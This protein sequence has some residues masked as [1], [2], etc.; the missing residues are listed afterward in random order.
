MTEVLLSEGNHIKGA[1]KALPRTYE[2][3]KTVLLQTSVYKHS[4]PIC[5]SL[6]TVNTHTFYTG[7]Y[8][9]F[10]VSW[11]LAIDS[12]VGRRYIWMTDLERLLMM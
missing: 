11:M 1:K 6:H 10:N 12:S 2:R 4:K 5:I 7:F 8:F 9:I 3:K